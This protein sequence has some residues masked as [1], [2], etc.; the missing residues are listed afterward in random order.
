M[1]VKRKIK[2]LEL[3]EDIRAKLTDAQLKAKYNLSDKT[4]QELFVKL[5]NAGAISEADLEGRLEGSEETA[6]A[7]G[8]RS[9]ARSYPICSLHVYDLDD[10]GLVG[11]LQ[12]LSEKGLKVQGLD[13]L[14]GEKKSL[15][16]QATAIEEVQP[17][18]LTAE[19][20][21]TEP[22]REERA[23][24]Y[25]IVRISEDAGDQLRKL[26]ESSTFKPGD[27]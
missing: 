22:Q 19:C 18:T 10:L 14:P 27:A 23:A 1:A 21:W 7:E 15:L 9:A 4:L 8:R 2:A 24:G 3:I 17:F 20:K 6:S 26:I 25:E 5:I 11:D 12:D 16:V 13:A